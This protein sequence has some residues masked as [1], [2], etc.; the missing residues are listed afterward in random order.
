MDAKTYFGVWSPFDTGAFPDVTD[1]NIDFGAWYILESGTIDESPM[2]FKE[3]DWLIYICDAKGTDA[4]RT[5]WKTTDGLA[6]FNRDPSFNTPDAGVYTKVTLDNKGNIVDAG[7]LAYEDLPRQALDELSNFTEK[8]L[9]DLVIDLI[10]NIFQSSLEDSVE[11]MYDP[12]TQTVHA[13]AKV[14]EETIDKNSEGYLTVLGGSGGGSTPSGDYAPKKHTH[15]VKDIEGLDEHFGHYIASQDFVAILQNNLLGIIDDTT[16]VVNP[17]GKLAVSE[18]LIIGG[19]GSGGDCANHQHEI[20]DIIGLE[21]YIKEYIRTVTFEDFLVDGLQGIVDGTTISVNSNGKLEAIA[22]KVGPHKH[23]MKDI[24]DLDPNKADTWASKQQLHNDEID[25][26]QGNVDLTS[27]NIGQALHLL[28]KSLKDAADKAEEALHKSEHLEPAEPGKLLTAQPYLVGQT[29]DVLDITKHELVTAYEN[30]IKIVTKNIQYLNGDTVNIYID[31][32]LYASIDTSNGQ[33]EMPGKYGDFFEVTY[34]GDAY[35]DIVTFQ[36]YYK[37][38]KWEFTSKELSEGYHDVIIEE[39]PL[40]PSEEREKVIIEN[41]PVCVPIAFGEISYFDEPTQD[42]LIDDWISG[43]GCC[44]YVNQIGVSIKA[45]CYNKVFSAPTQIKLKTSLDLEWKNISATEFTEGA[46]L[47]TVTLDIPQ[48]Y[49]GVLTVTAQ[50]RIANGELGYEKTWTSPYIN[51]DNTYFEKIYRVDAEGYKFKSQLPLK[52]DEAQVINNKLILA[53]RDFT[54]KCGPDYSKHKAPQSIIFRFPLEVYCSNL[55]FDIESP[56][57]NPFKITRNGELSQLKIEASFSDNI[58][59]S[60]IETW[61]DCNKYWDGRSSFR[62]NT[63]YNGLDLFRSNKIRRWITLGHKEIK[64]N[65]I[66]FRITLLDDVEID[67]I[68]LESSLKECINERR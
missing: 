33:V 62:D 24:T 4:E 19:G 29:F 45:I 12:S 46:G 67:L 53:S 51:R 50:A 34:V 41:I 32:E 23:T 11:F 64:T 43:V 38:W 26:T 27:L 40:L 59:I 44:K 66:Y 65:Y 3:G 30:K 63:A 28:N 22:M 47:Y 68:K 60:G 18:D 57:G 39:V 49:I 10:G 42:Q 17:D 20:S 25:W 1:K 21:D 8:N 31:G 37:G 15:Q 61:I 54:G 36:G 7:D 2:P 52:E 35:P 58:H 9:K 13:S 14:D 55:Y 56:D 16:L 48:N 5:F 6:V